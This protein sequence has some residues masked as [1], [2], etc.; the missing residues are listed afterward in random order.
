MKGTWE[1]DD[2]CNAESEAIVEVVNN[3]SN[4]NGDLSG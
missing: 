1:V 4:M 3:I 2:F